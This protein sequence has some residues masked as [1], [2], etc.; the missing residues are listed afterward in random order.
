MMR[1]TVELRGHDVA[2]R[3]TAVL[4]GLTL[5]DSIVGSCRA[6]LPSNQFVQSGANRLIVFSLRFVKKPQHGKNDVKIYSSLLHPR[7]QGAHEAC[8]RGQSCDT[9]H[10][11]TSTSIS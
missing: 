2:L 3:D 8:G 6:F 7:D 10:G 11:K 1:S 5:F 4:N 9:S